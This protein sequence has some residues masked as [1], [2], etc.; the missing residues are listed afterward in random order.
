MPWNTLTASWVK[1]GH[2][3]GARPGTGGSF[4]NE[5]REKSIKGR[6]GKMFDIIHGCERG[7]ALGAKAGRWKKS[8]KNRKFLSNY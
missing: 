5:G 1:V 2:G 6:N 4:L 7:V 3:A 8:P